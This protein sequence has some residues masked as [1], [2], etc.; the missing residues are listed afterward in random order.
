MNYRSVLII[1]NATEVPDSGEKLESLRAIVEH[2]VTGRWEDIRQPNEKEIKATKVLRIAIDEASAKI[3][4][5]PP[6]D[7]EEDYGLK[8]WAGE[9]PFQLVPCDPVPDP[10]LHPDITLP[11]YAQQC[12]RTSAQRREP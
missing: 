2:A 12:H 6:I 5:G 4:S 3:R 11:I 7:D 10:R 1:G 9:I 8:C